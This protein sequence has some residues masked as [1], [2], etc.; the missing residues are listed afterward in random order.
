[1]I[2]IKGS[3]KGR[4]LGTRKGLQKKLFRYKNK[5]LKTRGGEQGRDDDDKTENEQSK[6]GKR[7]TY[8]INA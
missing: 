7:G 1:M 5:G 8:H 3:G 2:D 6:E 4:R